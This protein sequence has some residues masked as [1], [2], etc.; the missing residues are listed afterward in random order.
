M[1][2]ASSEAQPHDWLWRLSHRPG[3]NLGPPPWL[4]FITILI[5]LVSEILIAPLLIWLGS[6]II[7]PG[8]AIDFNNSDAIQFL[9]LLISESSLALLTIYIVKRRGFNLSIIGLGRRVKLRDIGWAA[10][11]FIAIAVLI[12]IASGVIN[13]ISP[14]LKNQQ[15]NVGF[16]NISSSSAN[17]LAFI[18]L[19]FLPPLGE[20]TLLRGYL[21]SGLRK[22]WRFWPAMLVTSLMFAAPHLL[23]TSSGL[24]WTAAVDT[25]LL[26]LVLCFLRERTG[27]LYAGMLV[28]LLNNLI[29]FGVH[30]K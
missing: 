6:S 25:F 11:G 14:N 27:A 9:F 10:L 8:K 1:S 12:A 3:S 16:N 15:Q 5:F 21:F 2:N 29:A 26:S 30:F 24:L 18:A 23:E 19:V 7:H 28:H 17:A 4:I 22:F 20:E 13:F